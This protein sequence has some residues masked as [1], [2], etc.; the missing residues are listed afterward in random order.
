M[1]MNINPNKSSYAPTSAPEQ[2][3]SSYAPSLLEQDYSDDFLS[4]QG[5]QPA[6]SS[7]TF[8]YPPTQMEITYTAG[9]LG[10]PRLL[11]DTFD[12]LTGAIKSAV[13]WILASDA[14]KLSDSLGIVDKDARN[15]I[16]HAH[17]AAKI[18]DFTNNDRVTRNLGNLLEHLTSADLFDDTLKD[19]FNNEVGRRIT[20]FMEEYNIPTEARGSLVADAYENG[21][22]VL[23]PNDPR[24]NET[25]SW[26]G[27]STDWWY[28]Y[29]R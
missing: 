16:A 29:R 2:D 17:T 5:P 15:A 26:S 7:G 22:L 9:V 13:V 28:N 18:R 20:E 4:P 25:P 12:T 1:I 21:E 10:N 23:S 3:S 24:R 8:S 19:L 14:E 27:P 11:K 6:V